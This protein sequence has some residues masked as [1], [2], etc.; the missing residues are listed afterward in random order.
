MSVLPDSEEKVSVILESINISIQIRLPAYKPF[1]EW[2][3]M[4]KCK[5]K[6]DGTEHGNIVPRN[7][8]NWQKLREKNE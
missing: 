4:S 8:F 7:Y 2:I 3:I 5:A 6:R 1:P